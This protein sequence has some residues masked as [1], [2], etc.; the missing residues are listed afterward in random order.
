MQNK[1][2]FKTC[3][4]ANELESGKINFF[5]GG[6]I[7]YRRKGNGRAI[8]LSHLRAK[9]DQ[10]QRLK[11][12]SDGVKKDMETLEKVFMDEIKKGGGEKGKCLKSKGLK[13]KTG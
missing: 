4:N 10:Y 13:S 7:L 3:F 5:P 9:F 12:L 2:E 6:K 11:Q 8:D 1:I